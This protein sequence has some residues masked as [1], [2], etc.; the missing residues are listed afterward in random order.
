MQVGDGDVEE[1]VHL[2]EPDDP[3][4]GDDEGAEVALVRGQVPHAVHRAHDRLLGQDSQLALGQN[5][6]TE[7]KLAVQFGRGVCPVIDINLRCCN[8]EF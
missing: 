8:N 7:L 5:R 2:G 6:A 1:L 3:D 4:V